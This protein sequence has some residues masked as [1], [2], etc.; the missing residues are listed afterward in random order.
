MMSTRT[1][2]TATASIL[3]ISLAAAMSAQSNPKKAPDGPHHVMVQADKLVWKPLRPGAETAVVAGDPAKPGPFVM[4]FRYHGPVT[5]PPHW[6]PN[7]EHITVITGSFALGM[8]EKADE[9][10]VT[11]LTAGGYA[12]APA[13]MPHYAWAKG[14]TTLLQVHG[15]GPFSINYVNPADDPSKKK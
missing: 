12:L 14:E 3:M 15:M 1:G 4:R 8:G 10:A 9:K 7:D 6:H 5:V 2:L 13:K 11:T